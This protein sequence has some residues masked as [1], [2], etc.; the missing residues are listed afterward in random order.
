MKDMCDDMFK[1]IYRKYIKRYPH[2][3]NI[4]YGNW[5]R[6]FA[7]NAL[8]VAVPEDVTGAELHELSKMC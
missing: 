1:E 7:Q 6:K 5:K 8:M 4:R 3:A 2:L